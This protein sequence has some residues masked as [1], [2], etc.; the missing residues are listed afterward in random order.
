[1]SWSGITKPCHE[2]NIGHSNVNAQLGKKRC[3]LASVM[4]LVIEEMGNQPPPRY[5]SLSSVNLADIG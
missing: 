2:R 5:R 4:G 1:M 3:D